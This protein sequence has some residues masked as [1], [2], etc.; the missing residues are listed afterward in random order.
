MLMKIK[1]ILSKFILL[2]FLI[3]A[4]FTFLYFTIKKPIA[5]YFP[6]KFRTVWWLSYIALIVI[7]AVALIF[8][9]KKLQPKIE[10]INSK[11]AIGL[12]VFIT[13]VSRIL[14]ICNISVVPLADF[15]TY[16][17]F[18]ESM[19]KGEIIGHGY[20]ALFPHYFGYPSI[21][22]LFYKIFGSSKLVA[23]VLNVVI[24][25]GIALLL[26]KI[27]SKISNTFCGLISSLLW[28]LWPSQILY[29]SLI[30]TEYLYTFLVLLCTYF[31]IVL[32]NRKRSLRMSLILFL[33]FGIACAVTNTIRPLALIVLIAS[34]IYYTVFF[35]ESLTV[36]NKAIIT[37]A[38]LSIIM[39]LSYALT[40][41]FIA[42][43]IEQLLGR[44]ISKKPVGFNL[45][46]GFN[47][48]SR[49]TWNIEDSNTLTEISKESGIKPQ[50]IHDKLFAMALERVK[51]YSF[52]G[53]T[54]LL[55]D[56]HKNMWVTDHDSLVYISAGID[57]DLSNFDYYKYERLITKVSNFY[58]YLVLIL[59][60]IGIA[61][62][63]RKNEHDDAIIYFVLF[64]L[65]MISVHML[66]EVAG[67]YHFPAISLFSLV[68]GY[69]MTKGYK[70]PKLCGNNEQQ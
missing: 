39:V 30:C 19:S 69:S 29:T 17:I 55:M 8:I 44:E 50:Q 33:L 40:S 13:F 59:C 9:V 20:I 47:Y 56:K 23:L 1:D 32:I 43:S 3:F 12:I 68:A 26:Y 46:V 25:C 61:R 7:A 11:L 4:V 42:V 36:R 2:L 35:K 38:I 60:A 53:I 18:A 41:N 62:L 70:Y 51:S 52:E 49:G 31:F 34:V 45:Y 54:D 5:M 66:V 21:L 28:A 24:S 15:N 27:G 37:K 10:L 63:I 16:H 48:N 64:I 22:A 6:E 14:W 57:K 58:Y 65:G 67:R